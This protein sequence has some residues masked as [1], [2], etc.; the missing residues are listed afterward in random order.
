MITYRGIAIAV[1]SAVEEGYFSR[2]EIARLAELLLDG[3]AGLE[4][5]AGE[6]PAREKRLARRAAVL[7]G[8]ADAIHEELERTEVLG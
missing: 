7:G 3:A 2:D 8:I 6:D 4:F 1:R 5:T